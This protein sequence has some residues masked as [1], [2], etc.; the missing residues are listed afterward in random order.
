MVPRGG[1]GDRAV[2]CASI[3]HSEMGQK[4]I[5]LY[6]AETPTAIAVFLSIKTPALSKKIPISV[7]VKQNFRGDGSVGFGVMGCFKAEETFFLFQRP[8][9][10]RDDT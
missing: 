10:Y 4:L 7:C 6:I 8:S 9:L 2:L 1:V 5:L 3:S